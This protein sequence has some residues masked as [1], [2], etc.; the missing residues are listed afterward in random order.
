M[1]FLKELIFNKFFPEKCSELFNNIILRL[2]T[3]ACLPSVKKFSYL[4]TKDEL[5]KIL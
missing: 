3:I 2:I 5:L 1:D 4:I